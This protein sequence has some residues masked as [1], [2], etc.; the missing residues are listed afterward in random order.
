MVIAMAEWDLRYPQWM[1]GDGEP[2]RNVGEVFDWFAVEFWSDE[3]LKKSVKKTKS[4]I[5][6]NDF[7]YRIT[8]EVTYVSNN[9]CIIDFGLKATSTA[10]VLVPE[11]Q[12]GDYV[13]GEVSLGLAFSMQVV[14]EEVLKSLARTWQVNKIS[15]DLTPYLGY[16][17]D[18]SRI[19]YEDAAS[20]SAVNAHTYVLHCSEITR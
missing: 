11:F 5:A 8:A 15:A 13:M 3:K 17:R 14:T 10:D 2:D 20:T 9:A 19:R 4:A 12:E 7:K 1:I 16:A 18:S 6:I